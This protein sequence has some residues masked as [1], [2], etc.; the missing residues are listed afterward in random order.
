MHKAKIKKC[1][2]IKKK[3][4]E[5]IVKENVEKA[6]LILHTHVTHG[7]QMKLAMHGWYGANNI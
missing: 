2:F 3:V 5:H 7:I 1:D 6:K 4:V